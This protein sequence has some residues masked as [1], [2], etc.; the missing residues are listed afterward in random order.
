MM[1][2]PKI[3]TTIAKLIVGLS[4]LI[5][6][7]CSDR[8][9]RPTQRIEVPVE[10]Q[11]ESF[12]L[13]FGSSESL[14]NVSV[15]ITA[16]SFLDTDDDT[17]TESGD[18]ND[19][20]NAQ[21]IGSDVV[22][23]GYVDQ[24]NDI[25]D[26]YSV[27]GS[28]GKVLRLDIDTESTRD[29]LDLFLFKDLGDGTGEFVDSSLSVTNLESLVFPEDGDYFVEVNVFSG[30]AAYLLSVAD[31]DTT[32]TSS[33]RD[34]RLSELASSCDSN[35]NC[36]SARAGQWIMTTS[37]SFSEEMQA[38]S[39]NEIAAAQ[40]N[41][42]ESMG[43][44]LDGG[45]GTGLLRT[46]MQDYSAQGW[47]NLAASVGLRAVPWGDS[48]SSRLRFSSQDDNGDGIP[49]Q[50]ELL[51]T[52]LIAKKINADETINS[53]RSVGLNFTRTLKV[54]PNDD[55]SL[56]A[57][58]FASHY[59]LIRLEQAWD[60][61][62]NN[63]R[64][65]EEV[66]VAVLDTGIAPLTGPEA[67]PDWANVDTDASD[68][69][70][71]LR[72]GFDFVSDPDID[73]D[74][75]PGIDSDA[76]DIGPANNTSF[77]GTHVAG[78]VAA[79]TDNGIGV[80]GVGRSVS[81][82]PIRVLG[83]CGCGS[84]FDILQGNLYAAQLPNSSDIIPRE[85]A[86]IIN[87]SLG[88]GGFNRAAQDVY[89][90]V[91]AQG[92][93]IIAAAGNE[94][95]DEPSY[96]ASYEGIVS[97]SA[98]AHGEGGTPADVVLTG[99]SNFGTT[100][101]VAAPGG[102]S[103]RD[104]NG[105]GF[106]DGVLSTVGLPLASSGYAQF[107]GTSMAAPHVAGVA[108]L[109]ESVHQGLTPDEFDRVLNDRT[110]V[111]DVGGAG[112][113]D[114][115]GSGLIDAFNAVRIAEQLAGISPT[116]QPEPIPQPAD[117]IA[118][119]TTNPTSLNFGSGLVS[120]DLELRNSGDTGSRIEVLEVT[121]DSGALRVTA[122]NIDRQ[123]LGTYVAT[124][125]RELLDEGTN[126]FQITFD[127]NANDLTVAVNAV[128]R[129]AGDGGDAGP[130]HVVL[131]DAASLRQ[132]NCALLTPEEGLYTTEFAD[133]KSGDYFLL[134]GSDTDGDG[135]ICGPFEACGAYEGLGN[136]TQITDEKVD[137]WVNYSL[138]DQFPSGQFRGCVGS[139]IATT[140]SATSGEFSISLTPN[141]R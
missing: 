133:V 3:S 134:A 136:I 77:H 22:V 14:G 111:L 9:V 47:V 106:R 18:N 57:E 66:L 121:T 76:T 109:M 30:T 31:S 70:G 105:D 19:S 74:D 21:P 112:R 126:Q 68:S 120:L 91:R 55:P 100:V 17:A 37:R 50:Q 13:S 60:S 82:M 124:L 16:P 62:I 24:D 42:I 25:S 130:L 35:G 54:L 2:I 122:S 116:P 33:H 28:E 1:Y 80:A 89:A 51:L 44:M 128:V 69:S 78:T 141:K 107:N 125:D 103:S 84:T 4:I 36:A 113:D 11:V 140:T 110:I 129:E 12:S 49:D 131:L 101:D 58:Q 85:R 71:K 61:Q 5:T 94:S 15:N 67:H 27:V 98:V 108:A 64:G 127:T 26:W 123:G 81:I 72:Y 97:V 6:F 38:A 119:A 34:S 41:I 73:G 86:D 56:I 99:Y 96:P 59:S 88:G 138:F 48:D 46:G 118:N 90:D 52:A 79:P 115:F 83:N 53:L 65:L 7:G 63:S 93:I 87:M 8:T 95:T 75:I 102:R 45:A 20:A 39:K 32:Q 139:P 23:S 40:E 117:P 137:L 29:D 135:L 92:V 114:S 10:V 43:M 132:E 104:A